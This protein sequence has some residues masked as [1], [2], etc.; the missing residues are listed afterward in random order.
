MPVGQIYQAI[1]PNITIWVKTWAQLIADNKARLQF[2]QES[3]GYKVS[4]A[5]GLGHLKA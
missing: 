5:Q 2:Y 1:N 3:L 4:K